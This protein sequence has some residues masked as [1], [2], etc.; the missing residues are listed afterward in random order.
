MVKSKTDFSDKE[1]FTEFISPECKKSLTFIPLQIFLLKNLKSFIMEYLEIK[2]SPFLVIRKVIGA[3]MLMSGILFLIL[4]FM[5][6]HKIIYMLSSVT[7]VFTG[8][9]HLTNGFGLEKA[10]LRTNPHSITIK[11]SNKLN[12]VTIHVCGIR[13]ISLSRFKVIISQKSRKPFKLDIGYL[14]TEQKRQIYEFII[15]FATV[16]NVKLIRDF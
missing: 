15:G 10:W 14:E 1:I 5:E 7:F 11:W 9:Y 16:R 12:P 6:D 3:F 2:S 13:E 4:T 8:F